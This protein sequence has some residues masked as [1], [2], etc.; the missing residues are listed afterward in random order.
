MAFVNRPYPGQER[1]MLQTLCQY[2]VDLSAVIE[3]SAAFVVFSG[4]AR[5]VSRTSLTLRW[6]DFTIESKRPERAR[7][8]GVL[9]LRP[10][11]R[12]LSNHSGEL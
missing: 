9:G 7:R 6:M 5:S 8:S 1:V 12:E 11:P 10:G 2:R 4:M 3:I